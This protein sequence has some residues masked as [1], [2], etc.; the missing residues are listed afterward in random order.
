[1]A[2]SADVMENPE[3]AAWVVAGFACWSAVAGGAIQI[4]NMAKQAGNPHFHI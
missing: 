4:E 3:M 1:M 2:G